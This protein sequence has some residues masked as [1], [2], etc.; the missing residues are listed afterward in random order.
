MA[1]NM[2]HLRGPSASGLTIQESLGLGNIDLEREI[3][4]TGK[5]PSAQDDTCPV[6]EATKAFCLR[7]LARHPELKRIFLH[8]VGDIPH[9]EPINL[10]TVVV[11]VTSAGLHIYQEL[12][13]AILLFVHRA[14]NTISAG[15]MPTLPHRWTARDMFLHLTAHP[16]DAE[17]LLHSAAVLSGNSLVPPFAGSINSGAHQS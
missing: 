8:T 13:P 16:P 3:A 14:L 7:L 17:D 2:T 11:E 10:R 1:W 5:L 4:K 15:Y 9:E 6:D 12:N